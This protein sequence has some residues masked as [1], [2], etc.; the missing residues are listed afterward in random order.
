MAQVLNSLNP[1]ILALVRQAARDECLGSM[2]T[3]TC[4][5]NKLGKLLRHLRSD[6]ADSGRDRNPFQNSLCRGR[7]PATQTG[8]L[9]LWNSECRRNLESSGNSRTAAAPL[10][11]WNDLRKDLRVVCLQSPSSRH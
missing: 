10:E 11:G 9:R 4:A 8:V 5:C 3:Y 2:C 1:E 7:L 6:R